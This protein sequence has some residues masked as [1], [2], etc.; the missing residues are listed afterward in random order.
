MTLFLVRHDKVDATGRCYGKTDL[1][2]SVPYERSAAQLRTSLP[3]APDLV[4]SSPSRRCAH[5]AQALYPGQSTTID[6][7][8]QEVDFG[9]WENAL[10]SDLPRDDI[11]RWAQTPT[12]FQFPAGESLVQFRSRVNEALTETASNR[13]KVV[14]FTHAGVIRLCRTLTYGTDW[15]AELSA[16][17]PYASVTALQKPVRSVK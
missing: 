17:V 1:P 3:E 4:L 16:S 15:S 10:W 7:R 12:D 2:S 8:W 9:Q 14:V 5:L 11:D 13:G 6:P